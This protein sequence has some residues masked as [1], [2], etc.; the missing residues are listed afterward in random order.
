MPYGNAIGIL[1]LDTRFPRLPGDVGNAAT[2]PF[3]VTYRTVRGALPRRL[4]RSVPDPSL[5][6]SFMRGARD[7][8][9][10]GARAIL[11]SCG[12]LAAAQSA[13]AA[14]VP[15]PVFSSPLLQVPLAARTIGTGRRV[16]ILT[17]SEGLNETHFNGAG[18][19][20]TE[21][22]VVQAAPAPGSHFVETFVGDRPEARP[23]RLREEVAALTRQV[24][25]EHEI[26]AVVLECANFSPFA[27]TVRSIAKV[28]V[29]DLYTLGM[30]AFLATTGTDFKERPPTSPDE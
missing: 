8:A 20:A 23:D 1:M 6:E 22:P 21:I 4:V 14:A 11:T 28:P 18:W 16:A 24:V 19:S 7:L 27:Q 17:A 2:W 13:L 15:I 30:L 29:F 10:D 9:A 26:G 5:L 3:P 12:F 25:R